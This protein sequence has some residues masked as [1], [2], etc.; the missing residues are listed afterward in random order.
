MLRAPLEPHGLEL[1]PTEDEGA[2]VLSALDASSWNEARLIA[3]QELQQAAACDCCPSLHDHVTARVGS[4]LFLDDDPRRL[5][6]MF[7]DDSVTLRQL[8][9]VIVA[10]GRPRYEL[11]P[12]VV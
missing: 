8:A 3:E 4:V 7:H 12:H 11:Y 10:Y 9:A 6:A 2:P 5:M 1:H